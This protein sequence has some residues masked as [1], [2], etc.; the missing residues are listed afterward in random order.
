MEVVREIDNYTNNED[1]LFL[2]LGNFDGVH[3]GHQRLI[4]DL[5][6]KARASKG[7][8]AAFIFEP[9]PATVLNPSRAPKLLVSAKRKAELMKELGLDKLIYNRFDSAIAR[10]SPE[11]FAKTILVE[12]LQIKETFVGFNYSFGHKG[13]GTPQLLQELGKKYTFRVNII[14]PVEVN[15]QVVSSS[16]IRR[17][18]DAG[19]I[20]LAREMLG[21]CPMLEGEVIEGEKRGGTIGFP[22]ANLGIRAELNIPGKGVY[23]AFAEIEGENF[24]AA[25]NIGSKP[26]FHQEYPVS[27][28]AN[29]IDF[30]RQVYGQDIRLYFLQKIRD[31]RKFSGVDELIKQIKIDRE[32]AIRIYE[33][34]ENNRK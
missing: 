4:G 12:R 17:A 19:D 16:I 32:Q 1:P 9:H 20:Q 26:T 22:T 13:L 33:S 2:A 3:R 29:L 15:G 31:E 24:G 5:V 21:Y 10:C 18:L 6:Q 30:D 11:E 8:A 14:P 28:E 7:I 34:I 25:V 27:V 23:A